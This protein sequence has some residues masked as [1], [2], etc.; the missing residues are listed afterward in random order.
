MSMFGMMGGSEGAGVIAVVL[1][2]ADVREI[3]AQATEK[4]PAT[5]KKEK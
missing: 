3:A 4:A 5:E 2:A 1:P